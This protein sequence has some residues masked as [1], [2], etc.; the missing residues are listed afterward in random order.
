MAAQQRRQPVRRGTST[1]SSRRPRGMLSG[2][3]Q[4]LAGPSSTPTRPASASG[5]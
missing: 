4:A 1:A 2:G 3:A 5:R